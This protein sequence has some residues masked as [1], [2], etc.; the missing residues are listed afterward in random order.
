MANI[1]IPDNITP[2]RCDKILAQLLNIPRTKIKLCAPFSRNGKI[3]SAHDQISPGDVIDYQLLQE[4]N[5]I[6][7]KPLTLD[8]LYEDDDIIAINKPAGVIV[9]PAPGIKEKTLIEYLTCPLSSLGDADRPGVIHRLDKDTTGCIL[10]AKTDFAFRHLSKDFAEHRIDKRY[11]CIVY[12]NPPLNTG[13]IEVP[14]ARKMSDKTLMA[15]STD[16]KYA[17]TTWTVRERFSSNY[18]WLDVRIFTGRTHQ[19]RVHMNYIGHPVAGD[20]TYN[21]LAQPEPM[22]TFPRI[23]LHAQFLTFSHP[24]TGE[25]VKLEAPIPEDFQSIIR[26]LRQQ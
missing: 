12:G 25:I 13:K 16:G 26:Q 4:T 1:L 10:F 15:V 6:E 14:I 23:M 21:K 22:I 5:I 8:I 18:S 24:R 17:K 7:E 2:G 11:T 20:T 19:I 9:H 3:L